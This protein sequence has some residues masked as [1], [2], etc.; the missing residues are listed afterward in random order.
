[1]RNWTCCALT[2]LLLFTSSFSENAVVK[3]V[4]AYFFE[5][6]FG[7]QNETEKEIVIDLSVQELSEDMQIEIQNL[8]AE[9]LTEVKDEKAPKPD[10]LIY[11]THTDEAYLKG[12]Q[13]YVETSSGRTKNDKR[14]R[15]YKYKS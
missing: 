12:D 2:F 5:V 15:L 13:D 8:K 11:H 1:M 4:T 7:I 14:K 6:F 9:I 10:I 3:N